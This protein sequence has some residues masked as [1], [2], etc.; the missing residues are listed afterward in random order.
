M[1]TKEHSANLTTCQERTT[2]NPQK[3]ANDFWSSRRYQALVSDDYALHDGCETHS[4]RQRRRRCRPAA[5]DRQ[6]RRPLPH[7]HRG[8]RVLRLDRHL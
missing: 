4:R 3:Q 7:D 6:P 1:N 5:R 8:V 2:N